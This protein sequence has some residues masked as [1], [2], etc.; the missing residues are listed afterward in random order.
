[1]LRREND[2]N[3]L[4]ERRAHAILRSDDVLVTLRIHHQR[5]THRL[6]GLM[7]PR[8]G[9]HISTVCRIRFSAQ[10]LGCLN[11]IVEASVAA[12]SGNVRPG[13]LI[14]AVRNP[15]RDENLCAGTP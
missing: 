1:M 15:R 6:D 3:P 7:Y 14:D 5:E 9:E 10:G 4:V 13:T 12:T 11:E 2:G 8:V